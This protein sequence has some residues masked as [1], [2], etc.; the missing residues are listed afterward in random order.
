MLKGIRRTFKRTVVVGTAMAAG[1]LLLAACAT[2]EVTSLW[3]DQDYLQQPKKILVLAM[4]KQ[5]TNRRHMEDEFT[6][7]FR[8]RGVE[9][10]PAYT[11]LP[12]E[13]LPAEEAVREQLRAGGFD[14]LLLMRIV[15]ETKKKRVVPG[16]VTR[17]SPYGG[18]PGYYGGTYTTIYSPSYTV[19]DK[20]A[21]AETSLYDV[22]T[23]K[24]IWMARSETWLADP[25]RKL[26]RTYVNVMM[27][28]L[29]QQKLVP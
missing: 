21:I 9:A 7:H 23:E 22:A 5:A 27:G 1:V 20:Y 10:I 19:E 11:V 24:P 3:R 14:A 25:D 29:R 6:A 4:L 12:G 13:E 8:E 15:E 16:M 2:T 26:I 17:H 28:S 18:W